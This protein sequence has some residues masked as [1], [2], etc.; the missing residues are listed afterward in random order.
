MENDTLSLIDID[1][2]LIKS[3]QS[4]VQWQEIARSNKN[5]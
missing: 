2:V 4:E 5:N 3:Q 1:E